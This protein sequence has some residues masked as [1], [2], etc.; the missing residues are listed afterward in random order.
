MRKEITLIPSNTAMPVGI[1]LYSNFTKH[2]Q[3]E[4]CF[5]YLIC[6]KMYMKIMSYI[7]KSKPLNERLDPGSVLHKCM[8]PASVAN[9]VL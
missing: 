4:Y 6:N 1:I 5:T 8:K 2:C 7:V 3:L 9:K